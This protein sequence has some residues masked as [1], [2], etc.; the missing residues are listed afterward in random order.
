MSKP[1]IQLFAKTPVAGQVKTRLMSDIG[2]DKALS[3]YLHCLGHNLS[4]MHTTK[5]DYQLWL[6]KASDHPLLA[7][8]HFLL[9]QGKDLGEKMFHALSTVLSDAQSAYDRVILMGSDCL[10]LS[11]SILQKVDQKLDDYELVLVPAKDGGYVLIAARD[12]ITPHIFE[13]IDW[14]T[15]RVLT[16]TLERAMQ[17]DVSTFVLNP[18]RDIDRVSDLQHYAVLQNYL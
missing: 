14:S 15:D 9:Q 4:L 13:A 8:E 7:N 18:L 5:F 6:N 11:T 3:I 1:L 17:A 10:E 16:Q 12:S 2:A